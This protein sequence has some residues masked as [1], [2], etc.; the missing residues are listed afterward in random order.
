MYLYIH[1]VVYIYIYRYIVYTTVTCTYVLYML[2]I[3]M[4]MPHNRNPYEAINRG[5]FLTR[6]L[7][8]SSASLGPHEWHKS[9]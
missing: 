1:S 2:M 6:I 4:L 9:S 8:P 5:E 3:H 7:L